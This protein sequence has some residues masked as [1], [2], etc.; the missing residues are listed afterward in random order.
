MN[1]DSIM[2]VFICANVQRLQR[3]IVEKEEREKIISKKWI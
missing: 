2:N 1:H 3:N